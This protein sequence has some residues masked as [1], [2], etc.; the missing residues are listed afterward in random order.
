MC[1]HCGCREYPAI[2]EMSAEHEE[3]LAVAWQLTELV[4][5]GGG[6]GVEADQR[7][8]RLLRMLDIHARAEETAL[9]PLLV[10]RG[11]LTPEHSDVLEA[12]H[13]ELAAAILATERF[14]PQHAG[15]G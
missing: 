14:V 15:A 2:A 10:A 5:S 13:A 12:E 1:D 9:Y 11:D 6:A 7:R 8:A 4:R 3:I